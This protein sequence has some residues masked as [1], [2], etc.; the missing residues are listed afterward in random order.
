MRRSALHTLLTVVALV[1]TWLSP[2]FVQAQ[3]GVPPRATPG[4][5]TPPVSPYLNLLRGGTSAGVNY[6]GIVR[7]EI[8]F[9]NS[10]QSLQQQVNT[11]GAAVINEEQSLSGL[12]PTGHPVRFMNYSHYFGGS[13]VN[14]GGTIRAP[15]SGLTAAASPP[16][17]AAARAAT[18]PRA[19]PMTR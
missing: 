9:R 5:L 2:R 14:P 12:P 1:A 18:T 16:L 17:A 19:T 4:Y 3:P 6:Y 7:P 10:I 15:V 8:E 11:V 13:L